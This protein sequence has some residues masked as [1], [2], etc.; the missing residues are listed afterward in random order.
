MQARNPIKSLSKRRESFQSRTSGAVFR[1][2]HT[3]S[4]RAEDWRVVVL[5]QN[6][7]GERNAAVQTSD[8]FRHQIELNARLLEGLAVQRCPLTHAY[9]TL[10]DEE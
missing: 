9:H 5:V 8:V 6:G 7:H 2:P 4:G 10:M 3:E 1:E